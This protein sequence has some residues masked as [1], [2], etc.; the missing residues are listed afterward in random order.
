MSLPDGRQSALAPSGAEAADI[1]QTAWM[2][3]A[4]AAVVFVLILALIALALYRPP[5]WLGSRATVVVGG[6]AFPVVVLTAL[7]VHSLL[8]N[9]RLLGASTPPELTI[10]VVAEQWWW[11]VQ[12]LEAD[13]SPGFVTANEI[14]VPVGAAVE[15]RLRSADVLHSFWVPALA[16]KIDAIPGR[17]NRLILVVDQ[18][19]AW[20]GQC[21]EFCGGPHAQ[22][23]LDVIAETSDSFLRWR[24]AQRANAFA[25]ASSSPGAALFLAHCAVCHTVR[26]TPATGDRG[27][28]LTHVASRSSIGAGVLPNDAAAMERWIAANQHIKPGNLMPGFRA[29]AAGELSALASYLA[30]LR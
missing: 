22:M 14:R 3:F 21:A 2:L 30:S 1:A 7:L 11:R 20:R 16:G 9:P 23:A 25:G 26:G 5:R 29:F 19:G 12:Y 13:G 17:E 24:S 6:I 8:V 10:L 18:A 4:G 27:P 28:D 15:V